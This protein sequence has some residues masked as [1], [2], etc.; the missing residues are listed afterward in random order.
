LVPAD[1]DPVELLHPKTA[2]EASASGTTCPEMEKTGE[3]TGSKE[4]KPIRAAQ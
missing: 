3:M 4:R 2:S 1:G